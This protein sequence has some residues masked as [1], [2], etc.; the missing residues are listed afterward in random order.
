VHKLVGTQM[1]NLGMGE[2]G[3]KETQVQELV[4]KVQ[5]LVGTQ[6]QKLVGTQVQKLVMRVGEECLKGTERLA[7]VQNL[8]WEK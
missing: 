6:V 2:E 5:K 3:L 7:R 1:Q 4:M 8:E